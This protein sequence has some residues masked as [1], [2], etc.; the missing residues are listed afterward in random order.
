MENLIANLADNNDRLKAESD[1]I[2]TV[3]EEYQ[4]QILELEKELNHFQD[5]LQVFR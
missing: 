3:K 5:K 2:S 1:S 4:T